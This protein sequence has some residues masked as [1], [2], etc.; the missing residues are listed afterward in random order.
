MSEFHS[1]KYRDIEF[2]SYL[3]W[4]IF[5]RW[6]KR[7]KCIRHVPHWTAQKVKFVISIKCKID[8]KLLYDYPIFVKRNPSSSF[9]ASSLVEDEE[10]VLS[11]DKKSVTI[12]SEGLRGSYVL[13]YHLGSPNSQSS[14]SVLVTELKANWRDS[15]W[16]V[17]YGLFGGFI[18][19]LIIFFISY[20]S[21]FIEVIPY[22]QLI[23]K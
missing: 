22:Y 6:Y 11:E 10:C 1:G 20:F 23:G 13:E 9:G 3:L 18:G 2:E 4:K 17:A 5:G 8:K 14:N 15:K 16:F 12:M 7:P 19:S 21:G